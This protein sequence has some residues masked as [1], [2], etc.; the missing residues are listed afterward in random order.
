MDSNAILQNLDLSSSLH[1]QFIKKPHHLY[2]QNISPNMTTW[3]PLPPPSSFKWFTD[4][5]ASLW[6][7]CCHL[8]HPHP[9]IYSPGSRQQS[10]WA[11]KN[12]VLLGLC[13]FFSSG[14]PF[15]SEVKAKILTVA[16]NIAPY[17]L[18]NW[19]TTLIL[20]Y[21][22]PSLWPCLLFL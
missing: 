21:L 3:W 4:T 2:L 17:H 12:Q 20:V 10:E 5:V 8:P 15:H 7:P 13:S 11:F 14:F 16:N 19:F 9:T 6:R 1:I 18:V 22:A